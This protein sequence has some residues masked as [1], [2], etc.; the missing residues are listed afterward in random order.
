MPI[1]IEQDTERS[2]SFAHIVSLYEKG[3][4]TKGRAAELAGVS[5]YDVIDELCLRGSAS[6][7]TLEEL[8]EDLAELLAANSKIGDLP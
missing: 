1:I 5:I 4:I 7:Y 6:Q 3:Q 8:Q 2:H